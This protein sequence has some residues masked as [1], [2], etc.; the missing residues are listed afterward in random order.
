MQLLRAS[1]ARP[2]S[3]EA[4]NPWP[5]FVAAL[6]TLPKFSNCI[7]A[8]RGGRINITLRVAEAEQE[9]VLDAISGQAGLQVLHVQGAEVSDHPCQ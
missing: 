7:S 2:P 8:H 9:K 4:V 6:L 1:Q 5:S 3:P